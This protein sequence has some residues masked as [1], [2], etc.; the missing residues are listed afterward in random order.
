MCIPVVY[1]ASLQPINKN[2]FMSGT[3]ATKTKDQ[4]ETEGQPLRRQEN[5]KGC[6]L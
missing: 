2:Y 1:S 6:S 4:K 3:D 5:L